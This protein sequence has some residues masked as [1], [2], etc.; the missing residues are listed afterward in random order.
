MN[1][2]EFLKHSLVGLGAVVTLPSIIQACS[3][4]DDVAGTTDET[5]SSGNGTAD[6]VLS[7]SET[8]G[9]YPIISPSQYVRANIVGDRTGVGMELVITVQDLSEDCETLEGVLV[10]VWHCDKDGNYSQY[11]SYTSSN[12]LRGRQTTDANG[13]AIFTSVFPGWYRGRAPHIHVEVL[14]ASGNSLLASQIAFPT[15]VYETVYASDGYN[16]SPDTTNAQDGIFSD[17]LDLNMANTVSGSV[18]AGYTVSKTL[19]VS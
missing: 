13:Q 6:C 15:S 9:P 10:D 1:R 12:F 11:G 2:K 19:I 8:E 17:S 3:S 5:G 14:S 7:P 18:S 4:D 16:G